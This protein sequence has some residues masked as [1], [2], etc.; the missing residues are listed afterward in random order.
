MPELNPTSNGEKKELIGSD[1]LMDSKETAVAKTYTEFM[2]ALNQMDINSLEE[3]V[4]ENGDKAYDP[5]LDEKEKKTLL[6]S[7]K[8]LFN[9]TV[10]NNVYDQNLT[11]DEQ[12]DFWLNL[13]KIS[14]SIVMYTPIASINVDEKDIV[15]EENTAVIKPANIHIQIIA[16][17]EK[18]NQTAEHYPTESE[19][20]LV[21]VNN[22]W[23][24][25]AQHTIQ[26]PVTEDDSNPEEPE[27]LTESE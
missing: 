9:E 1:G 20:Q 18:G 12:L 10:T 16:V 22:K 24:Y 8:A 17:D 2:L 25:D 3:W 6:R 11:L 5:S 14:G 4:G 23:Y 7:V 13:S 26:N 15:F 21:L 19:V 27:V